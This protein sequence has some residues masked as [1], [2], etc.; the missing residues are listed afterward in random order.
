VILL[1]QTQKKRKGKLLIEGS[2][3]ALQRE[4]RKSGNLRRVPIVHLLL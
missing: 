2:T 1:R 4:E 3:E